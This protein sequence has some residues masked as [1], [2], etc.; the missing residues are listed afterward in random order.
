MIVEITQNDVTQSFMTT[1]RI[2]YERLCFEATL[3][4]VMRE[5][6]MGEA[7]FTLADAAMLCYDL[8]LRGV[9]RREKRRRLTVFYTELRSNMN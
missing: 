9:R 3:L 5:G 6:L 7:G 4:L 2:G 8:R 1:K